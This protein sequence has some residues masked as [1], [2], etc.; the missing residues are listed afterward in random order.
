LD[1]ECGA[2]GYGHND[3]TPISCSLVNEDGVVIVSTIIRPEKPVM[4]YLTPITGITSDDFGDDNKA[5]SLDEAIHFV[6]LALR[7]VDAPL[8]TLVGCGIAND[9]KWF[10]LVQGQDFS[11]MVDLADMFQ[12]KNGWKF[13]LARMAHRLLDVEV[14]EEHSATKDAQWSVE[15]YRR[16][17]DKP[18]DLKQA[19]VVLCMPGWKVPSFG[20]RNNYVFEGVCLAKYMPSKCVC[21]QPSSK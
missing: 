4:N 18:H 6:R 11:R 19:T 20:K 14:Y 9:V 3:R 1:I 15:L 8:P 17:V 12:A 10:R 13:P 7:G 16:Y 2:S 21:D 5:V